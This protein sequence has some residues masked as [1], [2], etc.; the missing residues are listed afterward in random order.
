MAKNY[1]SKKKNATE[2]RPRKVVVQRILAFSRS[3]QETRSEKSPL[4]LLKN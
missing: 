4:D 2:S 1:I 3:Y